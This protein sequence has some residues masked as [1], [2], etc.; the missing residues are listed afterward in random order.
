MSQQQQ[1]PLTTDNLIYLVTTY[2]KDPRGFISDVLGIRKLDGWQEQLLEWIANGETR[3]AIASCNGSGKTFITSAIE[4]WWLV[5]HPSATVS[6]C[7]ATYAQLIEV[8][9]REIRSHI[10]NSL[11]LDY[12]DISAID[13][14]RLPG[15]GDEAFISAVSNNKS[16]P[17]GIAGRHHG[18]LL[19]IFDEA[20]GIHPEIYMSQ[21]GNMSTDGAVWICIGNPISSGTAFHE[22]FKND[23]RWKTMHIDARKCMYTDKVWVQGM[24]DSYGIDDDRVRARILGE[25]PRGSVNT[26]VSEYDYDMAE[27]RSD[28]PDEATPA[29]IGLDVATARGKDTTVI[30]CRRGSVLVDIKEIVHKDNVDLAEQAEQYFKRFNAR[31]ICIDYSGGYGAG[32]GDI[33]GRVLPVGSVREVQFG[34]KSNDPPRWLNKRAE[35]WSKY[36]EWIKKATIPR[37]KTL[38]EDST[39]IEWWLNTK[40]QV[41]VEDKGDYQQRT[42]K[43]SPDYGDAVCCSLYVDIDGIKRSSGS[44]ENIISKM[45]QASNGSCWT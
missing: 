24:I 23:L 13:R 37:N 25:F 28:A 40:L 18:S 5:T 22:I 11:I 21:E 32:P 2:R 3:I 27:K 4:L 10:K 20:S 31:I 12:Y 9:M 16:R 39:G 26:C 33:L 35:L 43:G 42:R 15:S 29:V 38:R 34:G 1:I 44:A 7:S 45:R 17:E 6:V 19:T 14:I 41:Q 36:G 8:H 30:C